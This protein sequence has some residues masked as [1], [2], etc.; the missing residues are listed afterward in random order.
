MG[1]KLLHNAEHPHNI[2]LVRNTRAM[3]NIVKKFRPFGIVAILSLF[4]QSPLAG[5]EQSLP[6]LR[7]QYGQEQTNL[8]ALRRIVRSLDDIDTSF[9]SYFPVWSVLDRTMKLKVYEAFRNR[10]LPFDE[11][12]DVLIV[13]SPDTQ[14]IFD[15]RIGE[16]RYGRLFSKVV[17]DR[18][19]KQEL[20]RPRSY[21]FAEQIPLGYHSGK[22]TRK[23]LP[24][25]VAP[26]W[27]SLNIS[28]FGG[29]LHFGNSW[30]IVGKLGDDVL[31][32]PFWSS[33]QAWLMVKYK[34]IAIG[35][36]L[37]VHGGLEDFSLGLS[38]RLLNGSAGLGAEFEI[39]WDASR[40]PLDNFTYGGF[41]GS[42][43]IG[44]LNDR[45]VALF[46]SD[47]DNLYS[48]ST[49]MEAH[50]MFDYQF[51]RA[52]QML[53]VHLGFIHH[54]VTHRKLN[55]VGLVK[56]GEPQSFDHPYLTV[57]Y[58][59]QHIDWFK[60]STRF[61][62]LL[63]FSAWAEI[64]PSFLFVEVKYSTVLFRDPKPWENHSYLYGTLGLNF[65]F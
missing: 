8:Q 7:R 52:R 32:Y 5:Q 45:R 50:Y 54:T 65:S 29:S 37:P 26:D 57:Q 17:L 21:P 1:T 60:L 42:L 43:A 23:G 44:K 48:I 15:I 19:L 62:R 56:G 41:G 9:A 61:S 58:K 35:A 25:P 30:S 20:L 2:F 39:E 34:S 59:H 31:G 12:D 14:E 51:D 63:M 38:T 47:L 3:T 36:R 11:I 22:E 4:F 6:D 24:Q 40:I 49:L 46:T 10:N 28:L 53:N 13:A 55:E 16:S 18:N 64:V 27:I 33:G